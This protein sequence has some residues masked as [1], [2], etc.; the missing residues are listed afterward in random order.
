MDSLERGVTTGS[1]RQSILD[2]A[3]PLFLTKGFTETTM[4]DI[5]QRSGASTGSIYHHFENKEMLARALYLEGRTALYNVFFTALA[6]SDPREGIT[7]L[8]Y[9]YLQWYEQ[10]PDLGQYVM[11]AGDTEYLGAYVKVLRQK[12]KTVLP[13][14]NFPTQ[15]FQWLAPFVEAGAIKRLP[16]QVYFPL[17][18]GPSRDF[19]RRWLRERV[20]SEMQEAREPL[21]EAAWVSLSA[22]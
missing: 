15:F 21:A 14:E 19:T 11:Q 10:H 22:K 4:E 12:T 2:A 7:G 6:T 17:V 20:A 8:V 5:R 3:L 1:R 16:Q 18:I 13:E 9:A